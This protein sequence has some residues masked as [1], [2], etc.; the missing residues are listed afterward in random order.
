[1]KN[2]S[3]VIISKN[4]EEMMSECLESVSWA[5]ERIVVDDFSIDRTVSIARMKRAKVIQRVFDDFGN[6]RQAGID[7]ATGD[8]ILVLDA[9]EQIDA[10]LHREIE[11]AITSGMYDAYHVFFKEFFLNRPLP[12]N[13][14]GG[15][16]RVFRKGY[17]R[18]SK[19]TIH[20]KLEISGRV[21]TLNQPIL[22][23][24]FRSCTQTL[25]KF[26][27]YSAL[28]AQ[29]LYT[30]GGRFRL[31]SLV[32][33]P[34]VAFYKRFIS[35]KGY[36]IGTHGFVLSLMWA[37]MYFLKH[38]I[39]WSLD[40]TNGEIVSPNRKENSIDGRDNSTV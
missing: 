36:A 29:S 7:Q 2:L 38:A 34:M 31:V 5:T 15:C 30:Q 27:R 20:E 8:W 18:F 10:S 25:I 37:Y 4:E 19:Q 26:Q 11:T 33:S 17:G 3:V 14:K 1:M 40:Q 13:R 24:S 32:L 39:L 28:E 22:H 6:Q 23:F 9:D 16:V 21:G 12:L 35:L